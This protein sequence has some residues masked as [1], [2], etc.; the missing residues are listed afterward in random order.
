MA[1]SLAGLRRQEGLEAQDPDAFRSYWN[2]ENFGLGAG[3][4]GLP[5][6]LLTGRRAA[7]AEFLRASGLAGDE[8]LLLRAA[9]AGAPSGSESAG[10]TQGI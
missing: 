3:G 7:C 8:G 1:K 5:T 4:T 9:G 6:L 2:P 10:C